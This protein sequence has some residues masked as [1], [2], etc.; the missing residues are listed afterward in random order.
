M[1]LSVQLSGSVFSLP[2][3]SVC[4]RNG[5][6][7]VPQYAVAVHIGNTRCRR[8]GELTIALASTL[9]KNPDTLPM[10]TLQSLRMLLAVWMNDDVSTPAYATSRSGM[11]QET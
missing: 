7:I 1:Q 4:T 11:P 2:M 3:T 10:D 6:V 8:H 5:R 9:K